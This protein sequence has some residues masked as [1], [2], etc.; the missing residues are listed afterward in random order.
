MKKILLIVCLS[1]TLIADNTLLLSGFSK[2]GK[3]KDRF[4]E[5]F[6]SVHLG[7]G[8][9][10]NEEEHSFTMMA[11][12]DSYANMMYT[13][14]YGYNYNLVKVDDFSLRVGA[15]FG[16]TAKKIKWINLDTREVKFIYGIL[17]IA[18]IPT[19]SIDYKV[20]SINVLYVPRIK[21]KNS[22]VNEVTYLNFGI[23]F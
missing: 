20:Y 6:K 23:K 14:T 8:Y 3:T 2:H 22:V 12:K 9:R 21:Y 1:L 15:E 11:M 16:I 19:A 10:Y 18:F 7:L 5:K 17:P 4:G 13:A